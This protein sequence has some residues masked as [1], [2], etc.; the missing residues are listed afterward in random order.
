MIFYRIKTCLR[1]G[2]SIKIVEKYRGNKMKNRSIEI[3]R[4]VASILIMATHLMVVEEQ[5]G[6]TPFYNAWIY[7]EF[8]YFLTGYFTYR[9]FCASRTMDVNEAAKKA[10]KYALKKYCRFLPFIIIIT[11]VQYTIEYASLGS[12]LSNYLNAPYEILLL[13]EAFPIEDV[14]HILPFWYLSAMMIVFPI[15]CLLC[16]E[17]NKFLIMIL[18]LLETIIYYGYFGYSGLNLRG[19]PYGLL[20]A[21]SGML[22]GMM[23]CILVNDIG[24][25]VNAILGKKTLIISWT[26]FLVTIVFAFYNLSAMR[27]Y[28]I[29][30]IVAVFFVAVRY[31]NVSI[32]KVMNSNWLADMS[33]YMYLWHYTIGTAVRLYVPV[34]GKKRIAVYYLAT[35][36]IS[37]LSMIIHRLFKQYRKTG[38]KQND[39]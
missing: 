33:L 14:T 18:G 37:V 36:L 25:K 10:L 30:F 12:R 7:V 15:I 19:F 38:E 26:S 20:R 29:L 24:R 11:F 22:V 8:F 5:T 23:I 2:D 31:E 16:Q 9:H 4:L 17:K 13:T 6:E 3:W 35:V 39:I 28:V 1:S 32:S 21:F 27:L 34:V